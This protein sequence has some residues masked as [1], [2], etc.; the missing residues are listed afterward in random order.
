MDTAAKKAQE[1]FESLFC[2]S[3][4]TTIEDFKRD[5]DTIRSRPP[6]A[7]RPYPLGKNLPP[8]KPKHTSAAKQ[9]GSP[10]SPNK[11]K[12]KKG[13][14]ED[15]DDDDNSSGRPKKRVMTRRKNEPAY[16]QLGL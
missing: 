8:F 14:E 3:S 7:S 11:F 5:S 4:C 13:E 12:R 15:A 9:T 6:K 16:L 10:P 2:P 1:A